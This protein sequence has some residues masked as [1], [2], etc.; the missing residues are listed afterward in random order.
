MFLFVHY[1]D[2]GRLCADNVNTLGK[3][4]NVDIDDTITI[5]WLAHDFLTTEGEYMCEGILRESRDDDVA[6]GEYWWQA[7]V[8]D[9][10]RIIK[11]IIYNVIHWKGIVGKRTA[12]HHVFTIECKYG[13]AVKR[14][15]GLTARFASDNQIG[16]CDR[17]G[18]NGHL[19][20]ILLPV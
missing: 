7:F 4:I 11:T 19:A 13:F 1:L 20:P 12:Y 18:N 17:R 16:C 10:R 2:F 14:Q 5:S 3:R 6:I 8:D 15:D 9:V